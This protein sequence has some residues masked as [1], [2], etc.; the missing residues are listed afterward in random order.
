MLMLCSFWL[1]LVRMLQPDKL[2]RKL[3]RRTGFHGAGTHALALGVMLLRGRLRCPCLPIDALA[4][5]H[6]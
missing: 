3:L 1:T 6:N 4:Q 5:C 2:H